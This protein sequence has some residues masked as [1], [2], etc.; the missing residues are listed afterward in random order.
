[1]SHGQGRIMLARGASALIAAAVV[2]V[3]LG[4]CSDS[5]GPSKPYEQFVIAGW[6]GS[7]G[8]DYNQYFPWA[9]L[10][11]HGLIHV[12]D[13]A[14][15]PVAGAY[16]DLDLSVGG[17]SYDRVTD[18]AGNAHFDWSGILSIDFPTGALSACASNSASRC[19]S[20]TT[21]LTIDY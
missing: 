16:M 5:S 4:G 7:W 15:H 3:L 9:E 14:G 1:M 10:S 18:A 19:D 8:L 12:T 11:A 17:V 21:V 2:G 20:H 13:A 6:E